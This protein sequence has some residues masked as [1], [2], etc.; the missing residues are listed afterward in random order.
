MKR[1]F[2]RHWVNPSWSRQIIISPSKRISGSG[3]KTSVESANG[4]WWRRGRRNLDLDES[5][6]WKC[7]PGFFS[8]SNDLLPHS[9][10]GQNE[11]F[12]LFFPTHF[13]A[14][15]PSEFPDRRCSA[16]VRLASRP[17]LSTGCSIP[18]TRMEGAVASSG[19]SDLWTPEL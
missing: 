11:S 9:S 16:A 13:I 7:Y 5:R 12:H 17:L 15:L 1:C 4:V 3:D 2:N 8:C 10:P 6:D 14:T 19:S 18:V